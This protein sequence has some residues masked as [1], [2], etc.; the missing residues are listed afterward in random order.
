M[1]QTLCKID[2]FPAFA[3]PMMSTLNVRFGTRGECGGVGD[4]AGDG[5]DGAGA[6]ARVGASAGA[7]AGDRAGDGVG[8]GDGGDDAGADAGIG[9]SAGAGA[10]DSTE[11]GAGGGDGTRQQI[12]CFTPIVRKCCEMKDWAAC[13]ER[14]TL[15]TR[16]SPDPCYY[17][18][19]TLHNSSADWCA[20][21]GP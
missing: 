18:Y 21:G 14:L 3:F 11:A 8:V 13:V 9:A 2:V 12:L 7:V 19:Y 20:C 10:G 1:S 4:G 16:R 15:I 5:A 17:S 6:E